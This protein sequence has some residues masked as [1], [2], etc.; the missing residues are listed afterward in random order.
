MLGVLRGNARRFRRKYG[1]VQEMLGDLG[2]C[3]RSLGGDARRIGRRFR[4][5][6]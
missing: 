1:E 6:C 2:G 4:R 3:A 5:M